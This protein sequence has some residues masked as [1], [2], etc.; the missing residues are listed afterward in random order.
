[1]SMLIVLRSKSL[2]MMERSCFQVESIL[3]RQVSEVLCLRMED[4]SPSFPVISGNYRISGP[5]EVVTGGR[6]SFAHLVVTLLASSYRE[7]EPRGP[8]SGFALSH[9]W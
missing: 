3:I 6:C 7:T 4:Q 2:S 1:M 8:G 9:S 5:N